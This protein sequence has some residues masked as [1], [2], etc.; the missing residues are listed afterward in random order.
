METYI[1]H[2][3]KEAGSLSLI[4]GKSSTMSLSPSV[5]HANEVTAWLN[6]SKKFFKLSIKTN[7]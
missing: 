7:H 6:C 2:P 4:S 1:N 5:T 3:F